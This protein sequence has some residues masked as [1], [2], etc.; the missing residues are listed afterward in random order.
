MMKN[1]DYTEDEEFLDSNQCPLS[2][3]YPFRLFIVGLFSCGRTN[4]KINLINGFEESKVL[5]LDF[6]AL[7]LCAKNI[8]EPKYSKLQETHMMFQG[9]E[10]K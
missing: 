3:K 8:Y 7:Y 9:V 1:K 4:L 10:K 5:R 6:K 2:F